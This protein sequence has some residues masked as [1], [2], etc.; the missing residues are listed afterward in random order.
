MFE[1]FNNS[2]DST[3]GTYY[4][5]EKGEELLAND[6]STC[7][8]FRDLIVNVIQQYDGWKYSNGEP[9]SKESLIG[10]INDVRTGNKT[11]NHVTS[12]YG[13]RAKV[14]ELLGNGSETNNEP[15]YN[16][17]QQADLEQQEEGISSP[18]NQARLAQEYLDAYADYREIADKR[19]ND[20][21][22]LDKLR[23][24]SISPE[25]I[26]KQ[27]EL[28]SSSREAEEIAMDKYVKI[29]EK[30]TEETKDKYLR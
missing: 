10:I 25:M 3:K 15:E 30:L 24:E 13:L 29:G 9:I 7:G 26:A 23:D 11:P 14:I 1:N 28:L 19:N 4:D 22:V 17:E 18:E 8:D 5:P 12:R 2:I 6:V 21:R 16:E 27:E 20:L